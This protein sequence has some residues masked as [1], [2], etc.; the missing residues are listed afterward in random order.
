M[1]L[2]IS[3]CCI[4]GAWLWSKVL[5]IALWQT[6]G[7]GQTESVDSD[8]CKWAVWVR[9]LGGAEIFILKAS[10][11]ETRETWIKSIKECHDKKRHGLLKGFFWKIRCYLTAYKH[12]VLYMWIENYLKCLFRPDFSCISRSYV[13]RLVQKQRTKYGEGDRVREC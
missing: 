7:I 5:F 11:T 10:S 2:L 13:S 6:K 9:K 8:P 4:S 1:I 12:G 3:G